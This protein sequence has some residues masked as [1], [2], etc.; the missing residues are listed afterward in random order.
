MSRARLSVWLGAGLLA[1]TIAAC[2]LGPILL[3]DAAAE[4]D[5]RRQSGPSR[6]QWLGTDSAGRDLF[7]R[8][9]VATPR[10]VI[11]AVAAVGIAAVVGVTLG[12]LASMAGPRA[13][14]WSAA[15]IDVMQAV[16]GLLIAFGVVLVLGPGTVSTGVALAIAF[17]PGFCRLTLT[18]A[19]SITARDFVLAARLAGVGPR[20]IA[21]VHVLPNI[22][23]PL[24]AR[25]TLSVTD[26][27]IATAALS[28]IGLGVQPPD[29]DWGRMLS[30]ALPEIYRRPWMVVGPTIAIVV[31]GVAFSLL[32]DAL[33]DD[34]QPWLQRGDAATVA[35]GSPS[36]APG[37]V[38]SIEGL[39]VDV[40]ARDGWHEAV[41]DVDLAVR[42]GE[43]VALVGESGAG[44]S[45]TAMALAGAPTSVRVRHAG[46]LLDGRDVAALRGHER[47]RVLATS[48]GV[49]FQDPVAALNPARRIGSQV[50]EVLARHTG[51]AR[52]E[53]RTRT[54][55]RF[56]RLGLP[57]AE[58]LW[59][60]RPHE[61]SGGMC[62]RVSIAGATLTSP[63]LVIA[64]EATASID[65]SLRA[66]VLSDLQEASDTD[67]SGVLFVSHD[68][69][70]VEA[71]CDRVVV[72]YAG[73]VVE[74]VVS[75]AL[76]TAAHPY[77]RAL[78][79]CVP[80]LQSTHLPDPI[81]GQQLGP[82]QRA[83]SGCRYADRCP[84]AHD[85]CVEEPPLR[86]L[87]IGHRVR[88]W[89]G[90]TA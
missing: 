53:R 83:S 35:S 72:M 69:G 5:P 64:D 80:T 36:A 9:M 34:R 88:C 81:D 82:G 28:F 57:D 59:G 60:R 3:S 48:V 15:V 58:S 29:T 76:A 24:S 90:D 55:E 22:A 65:P 54:I 78:L 42:A 37:V 13:R 25:I 7:A 79:A 63:S 71:F 62:Q 27:L 77:T 89:L 46:H 61:L 32:G 41:S 2:V 10:S 49:V 86:T 73:R 33:T 18:L 44:K 16:P 26:A 51:A 12:A 17:T 31:V 21:C 56:T 6:E 66:R 38:A 67:G 75:S 20:R 50:V 39:T 1:L 4:F 87:A 19:S 14:R 30:D 84:S 47:D 45:L 70:L 85:R 23:R 68:L 74:E 43:R 11:T 52:S 40:P 8:L